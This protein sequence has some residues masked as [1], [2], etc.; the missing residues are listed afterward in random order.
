VPAHRVSLKIPSQI[1]VQNTDIELE[2]HS[3]EKKLG[4][5]KISKGSI[6]WLP[7]NHSVNHVAMSWEDFA[8]L[9]NRHL[10]T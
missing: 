6:D 1:D 7:A 10:T 2:V 3:D 8:A 4:T 9:M 5:L